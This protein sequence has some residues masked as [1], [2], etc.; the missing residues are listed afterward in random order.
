MSSENPLQNTRWFT[1][2]CPDH[3]SAFAFHIKAKLH[4][5]QSP[6]QKIAI[7]DTTH[8]G[9][10]MTI[11]GFVM[12][13]TSDNFLYHEMMS[14]P[15]MLTHP[16]AKDVLIVGGGDCGTLQQVLKHGS[17][18]RAVQ[19]DIDERV[20][21]LSEQYFP[22]L[23]ADNDDPRAELLFA[24]AIEWIRNAESE[25]LDVIIIDSTDP[26]GPAEGLFGESFYR[27]CIKALRPGG[28]LCQQSESPLYH[29]EK[30]IKP[31]HQTMAKAG[32]ADSRTY[33]FPQPVYPSGW[34]SGTMASKSGKIELPSLAAL[35]ARHV[36]ETRFYSPAGHLGAFSRP[37]L[38]NL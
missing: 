9:K 2:D 25:S 31:M 38:N 12:L 23:C 18:E 32:F 3:G 35:Q 5:E 34:W 16:E 1:E 29:L 13:T 15:V 22:E 19:V 27:D 24:D 10:L 7:Y 33:D 17:V 30:I 26:I 14:H 37:M 8:Y 21:R 6:F 28:L 11:D 36:F 4:E 20:T